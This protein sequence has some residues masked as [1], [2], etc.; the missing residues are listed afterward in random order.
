MTILIL[1]E[2]QNHPSLTNF[3]IRFLC[4][5][6][7]HKKKL[8]AEILRD[9]KVLVSI[10][11]KHKAAGKP[12]AAICAAPAVILAH[13]GLLDAGATCYPAP[14]FR[15]KLVDHVD[16]SVAVTGIVTTSQ[17]PGTALE[18]ALELGEQ[19]FGKESRDKVQKEM[20]V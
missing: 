11:E 5:V 17:G 2:L 7:R 3:D 14:H 16:D 13:H 18:F 15:G 10:L 6:R 20:L 12:Y 8:G 19:L 4:T 1:N 9:S